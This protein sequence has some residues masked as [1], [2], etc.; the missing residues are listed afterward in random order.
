MDRQIQEGRSFTVEGE[1][2]DDL[3]EI[4]QQ[5]WRVEGDH[6]NRVAPSQAF[7]EISGGLIE[8]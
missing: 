8:I 2:C 3:I 6:T 7:L 4:I 5:Q 1:A